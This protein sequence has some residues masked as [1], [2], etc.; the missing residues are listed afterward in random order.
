MVKHAQT[1]RRQMS[2]NCLSMFDHFV[3][4]VLE[5]L[6]YLIQ[7]EIDPFCLSNFDINFIMNSFSATFSDR[8]SESSA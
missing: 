6:T 5:G 7:S 3:W 4:L 8:E 1:I 2:T